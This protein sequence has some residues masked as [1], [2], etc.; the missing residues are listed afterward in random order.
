MRKFRVILKVERLE[1]RNVPTIWGVPWPD[2]HLTVSFAPDGTLVENSPSNLFQTLGQARSREWQLEILKALQTWARESNINLSVVPDSGLPLG[3]T[4]APQGDSR[5]GDIRIAAVPLPLDVVATGNPF[6]W[7][8]TWS[9]DIIFNSRYGFNLGGTGPYDLYSITLHEAGHVFGLDNSPLEASVMY[10]RYDGVRTGLSIFDVAEIQSLYGVREPDQFDQARSNTTALRATELGDLGSYLSL[11]GD[12]TSETDVD[13]Y[14]FTTAED[15]ESFTIDLRV[16]SASLLTARVTVY[17]A[18]GQVVGS[19]VARDPLSGD[20]R[21]TVRE[22]EGNAKYFIKVQGTGDGLFTIGSYR[23]VLR[24]QTAPSSGGDSDHSGDSTSGSGGDDTVPSDTTKDVPDVPAPEMPPERR[25]DFYFEGNIHDGMDG[26]LYEVAA[27]PGEEGPL[28]MTVVAWATGGL[29]P[30]VVVY[31]AD[32]NALPFQLVLN[33]NGTYTLQ[34][35][36]ATPGAGYFIKISGLTDAASTGDYALGV[37]FTTQPLITLKTYTGNTLSDS[38]AES[39]WSLDVRRAK[40]FHFVLS[41]NTEESASA[42]VGMT[43]RD[44]A[45]NVL[46]SR[47]VHTGDDPVSGLIYL[48]AG[49]YTISFT[50]AAQD[51]STPLTVTYQ[52]DGRVISNPIGPEL[53]D[54]TLDPIGRSDTTPTGQERIVIVFFTTLHELASPYLDLGA[55]SPDPVRVD[56]PVP[57]ESFQA[58]MASVDSFLQQNQAALSGSLKLIFH[59]NGKRLGS[60][61][62]GSYDDPWGVSLAEPYSDPWW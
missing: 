44:E 10:T 62:L 42:S 11:T 21:I 55:S 53:I 40:L 36:N 8:G 19:A 51:V 23:L 26:D 1:D 39:V 17:D 18:A 5:F 7:S 15:A 20:I 12:I 16:T 4:G 9:G 33:D 48:T 35:P 50:A 61:K 45:G 38:T 14:K 13:Y 58:A 49:K 37:A 43:I 25:F 47:T 31:D 59:S 3:T 27:P 54:P 46:F 6:S 32:L 52:L 30:K 56:E 41:A 22:V 28:T 29:Q 34:I 2:A 60:F 24:Q 57:G